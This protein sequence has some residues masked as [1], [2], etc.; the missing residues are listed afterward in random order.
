MSNV[1]KNSMS[2]VSMSRYTIEVYHS[3][4]L[5]NGLKT[6]LMQLGDNNF[7]FIYLFIFEPGC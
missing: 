5:K 1:D 7:P 3:F 6:E 2:T 4:N